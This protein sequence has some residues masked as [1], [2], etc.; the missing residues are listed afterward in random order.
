MTKTL[1][2]ERIVSLRRTIKEKQKSLG[3]DVDVLQ[4]KGL[5]KYGNLQAITYPKSVTD[6]YFHLF[7]GSASDYEVRYRVNQTI[8][9]HRHL[10][11]K[12]ADEISKKLLATFHPNEE[13]GT[14]EVISLVQSYAKEETCLQEVLVLEKVTLTSEETFIQ[15][16][17]S[18]RG[19]KRIS[20]VVKW[21]ADEK[22]EPTPFY[23]T[24]EIKI[25]PRLLKGT[26]TKTFTGQ[27][28]VIYD[29][30][31]LLAK[32]TLFKIVADFLYHSPEN[33]QLISKKLEKVMTFDTELFQSLTK[34]AFLA[35]LKDNHF[36]T[37]DFFKSILVLTLEEMIQDGMEIQE[38][39][40]RLTALNS[41]YAKTYMTKKN[42]PLKIQN[43]MKNNHFLAMFGEVEADELCDL[44]KLNQLAD[45]FI[46]LSKQLYLPQAKDHS[47]RFRRLGHHKA[48]GIYYPGFNT[49]AVDIDSPHSFIHEWFHLIDFENLLLSADSDFKPLLNLYRRLVDESVEALG[50]EDATYQA[51]FHKKSK[52]SR[53]YYLSNEE[54][55]ARMG[56]LYVSEILEIKS[57]FNEKRRETLIEQ[58]VYPTDLELMLAIKDYF[59]GLFNRLKALYEAVEFPEKP[60]PRP[61]I[62]D[63]GKAMTKRPTF[64]N[65]EEQSLVAKASPKPMKP[66]LETYRVIEQLSLE[67]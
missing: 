52:Y 37:P 53:A 30:T 42:I 21:I 2:Q 7:A 23:T 8:G 20:Q 41:S 46:L 15:Q 32:A 35:V 45:E 39:E 65:L 16:I 48:A 9:E 64:V 6:Y 49:L 38:L 29:V 3:L 67:F 22:G 63:P 61:I 58:L 18:E 14:D 56:E 12:I 4:L 66:S 36:K 33:V 43:F 13:V 50:E 44:E 54:A 11:Q 5:K 47:L 26:W 51:W 28:A 59:D 17:F 31:D 19:K 55:F 10:Y 60:M 1:E 57:S 62:A 24:F 34:E 25:P 27:Q 40:K